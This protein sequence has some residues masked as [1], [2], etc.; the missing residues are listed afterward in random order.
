MPRG[1]RP[2]EATPTFI[3][4]GEWSSS[5]GGEEG[6]DEVRREGKRHK[7]NQGGITY[8]LDSAS[9]GSAINLASDTSD[10]GINAQSGDEDESVSAKGRARTRPGMSSN[11]Q[12]VV[13]DL[14]SDDDSL[15]SIPGTGT[16]TGTVVNDTSAASLSSDKA[17]DLLWNIGSKD[18]L[19][20][21]KKSAKDEKASSA[22]TTVTPTATAAATATATATATAAPTA[23]TQEPPS[24]PGNDETDAPDDASSSSSSMVIK[25][26][27]K[28]SEH[29]RVGEDKPRAV[30]HRPDAVAW[31]D[32]DRGAD[33]SRYFAPQ[34]DVMITCRKCG[35]GGHIAR[36]C[37]NERPCILCGFKHEGT[38]CEM[39]RCFR[40]Y[41]VGHMAKDCT[42]RPAGRGYNRWANAI[43][44]S[45]EELKDVHASCYNCGARGHTGGTCRE[46]TV[47]SLHQHYRNYGYLPRLK[48]PIDSAGGVRRESER[49][50][51]TP[52]S[53]GGAGGG[54]GGRRSQH[55]HKGD[56][57][58]HDDRH[59]PLGTG[60]RS[61]SY[62]GAESTS[63]S[64]KKGKK[65]KK[66]E[67]KTRKE[68]KAAKIQKA[69]REE[70]MARGRGGGK[71]WGGT[72]GSRKRKR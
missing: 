50:S 14:A 15:S 2:A 5:S 53:G 44:L 42:S 46:K 55:H 37:P 66:E 67:K 64:K 18:K 7:N 24:T 8:N 54:R 27:H 45:A 11:Q 23:T 22:V 9:Q 26:G 17:D 41:G 43:P 58:S 68:R 34:E 56:R 48:I 69:Y 70:K 10:S 33:T 60:E 40:C 1:K 13:F 30:G 16:R 29:Q 39:S 63:S 52:G 61:I 4:V 31:L 62:H 38:Q 20:V 3:G 21:K 72:G 47:D 51:A 32:S 12:P 25:H 49:R 65:A 19:S 28:A 71:G 59:R 6:S 36:N 35:E 57:A